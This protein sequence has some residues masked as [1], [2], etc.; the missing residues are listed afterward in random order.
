MNTEIWD[1]Y[2]KN[3]IKTG[4]TADRSTQIPSG[5]FRTVIHVIILDKEKRMLIQQRQP[6]KNTWG[7]MWDLSVGGHVKSGETSSEGASRELSEELGLEIS[8]DSLRPEMTVNFHNGFDDIYIINAQVD[9]DSLTLQEEEVK[10][11][12]YADIKEIFEMIDSGDFIPYKK[13][14]ISL[15]FELSESSGVHDIKQ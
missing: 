7:G 10:D 9:V 8:P 15:I 5:M 11:V 12:R 3:H 13:S 6:F 1:L 2:D 14:F 4:L